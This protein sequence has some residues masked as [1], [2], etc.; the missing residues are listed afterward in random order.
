MSRR[1]SDFDLRAAIARREFTPGRADVADLLAIAFEDTSEAD[2]RRAVD[3]LARVPALFASAARDAVPHMTPNAR[4]RLARAAKRMAQEDARDL[5]LGLLADPSSVVRRAAAR[6]VVHVGGAGVEAALLARFPADD[7]SEHRAIVAALGRVGGEAARRAL[8]S[9]SAEDDPELERILTQARLMLTRTDARANAATIARDLRLRAPRDVDLLVRRGLEAMLVASL[10][11]VPGIRDATV[12]RPGVVRARFDGPLAA[13]DAS[14]L[15]YDVRFPLPHVLAESSLEEDVARAI[16]A[17]AEGLLARLTRGTPRLR[18]AFD[19]GRKRRATAWTIA[20]RLAELGVVNDPTSA[21]WQATVHVRGDGT[22]RL[23]LAPR[24]NWDTRFADRIADVPASTHPTIAA[25]MAQLCP[26]GPDERVWDPFVGAGGELLAHARL[27]PGAQR[28]GT[29]VDPRALEAAR[30]NFSRAG[31]DATLVRADA[32]TY[33][34]SIAPTTIVTNPP[35]G[36]RVHRGD[37]R[38]VLEAF[39]RHVGRVAAPRATLV[40]LSPMPKQTDPCLEEGGF[41]LEARTRID[42]GGFEVGLERWR[43]GPS[44]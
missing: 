38:A 39:A 8:A 42:M 40:W 35:M 37:A 3:A 18:V 31:V 5:L 13:L 21:T 34:P 17:E 33:T 12:L 9:V 19:D 44:V 22:A 7:P 1:P 16:G 2:A 25:A 29:D 23:S 32:T 43:R 4:A 41:R 24:G 27:A 6:A 11:D 20:T 10:G 36:R 26:I 14:R 28:L 15:H 30:A